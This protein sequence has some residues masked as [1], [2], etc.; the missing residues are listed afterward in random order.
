MPAD[1]VSPPRPRAR[2]H[3]LSDDED[4][5]SRR[6][7]GDRDRHRRKRA[8]RSP[9][10][11]REKHHRSRRHRDD[12][13]PARSD[14]ERAARKR[15][16]DRSR[17]GRRQSKSRSR[18]KHR[19]RSRS[20]D[21]ARD[22]YE[23]KRRYDDR[24]TSPRRHHHH[25]S[26]RRKDRD[27]S[28]RHSRRSRHDRH[29]HRS[30]S[31]SPKRRKPSASP[32]LPHKRS[33]KPLPS[34]EAAYKGSGDGPGEAGEPAV[35]K[36]KPNFK[37]TGLLAREA[38]T[39]NVAGTDIVLKYNEPPDARKPPARD[40]WRLFVFKGQDCLQTVELGSRSCWL[41]GREAAVADMLV[42]HP[43]TSK[44]HAA[45]QFRHTIRVNEYGDKD[46]KVRPYLIDLESS[47]GTF[48]NGKQI[49]PTRFVEAMD[50]DVIKF[51]LS[52]REYV[53][54]LAGA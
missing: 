23:R 30:R 21:A 22:R 33:A 50:K 14:D 24:S 16:R 49:E 11:S 46:A 25:R 15:G 26:E 34:Q 48:L 19:H 42:E 35:E 32:E 37:Q 38:N 40:D 54:M 2:R 29:D 47:N 4:T 17:E 39:V 6:N 31:R 53:L 20:K 3:S 10:D 27:A 8:S 7:H 12:D 18:S 44:Q 45:L 5:G 28:P 51:G 41:I 9:T 52:E 36:Q 43:S 13:S 1:S